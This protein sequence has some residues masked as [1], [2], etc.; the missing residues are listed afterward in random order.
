MISKGEKCVKCGMPT[1]YAEQTVDTLWIMRCD[2]CGFHT[3]KHITYR[4]AKAEWD[5]LVDKEDVSEC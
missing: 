4:Q 1:V 2:N 3:N 5:D